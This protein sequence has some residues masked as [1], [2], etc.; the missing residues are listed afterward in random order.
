MIQTLSQLASQ[1][2]CPDPSANTLVAYHGL[3]VTH[4]HMQE[5]SYDSDALGVE[6]VADWAASLDPP[7]ML[8]TFICIA[9]PTTH[10]FLGKAWTIELLRELRRMVPT[11]RFLHLLSSPPTVDELLRGLGTNSVGKTKD[12]HIR[13]YPTTYLV[14]TPPPRCGMVC[15]WDLC[16]S[17]SRP[18]RS[19]SPFS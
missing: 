10:I 11:V 12:T 7:L 1:Q 17:P 13:V 6:V 15:L 4:H 8:F 16:T 9:P 18:D 14:H 3:P 5:A 19:F 2:S